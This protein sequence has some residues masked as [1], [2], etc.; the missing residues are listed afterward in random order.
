MSGFEYGLVIVAVVIGLALTDVAQSTHRLLVRRR[1]VRWDPLPL[2]VALYVLLTVVR[3]WFTVWRVRE[4]DALLRYPFYVWL[5]AE[6]FV[7]YLLAAACLPDAPD[8]EGS[9][10]RAWYEAQRRYIWSLFALFQASYLAHWL[11]FASVRGTLAAD[12]WPNVLWPLTP[13]LIY[14]GLIFTGRRTLHYLGLAAVVAV[15]A[16]WLW[17]MTL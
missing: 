6:L 16:G 5:F 11:Y 1:Q 15:Q 10:L 13:L 8:G 9:D 2:L 12:F 3:M 14:L 4:M 17:N 7:L